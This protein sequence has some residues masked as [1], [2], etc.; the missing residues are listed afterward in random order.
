ML[1]ID[2][3]S[4]AVSKV[5]KYSAKRSFFFWLAHCFKDT[6]VNR[7]KAAVHLP[8]NASAATM[9]P[10]RL[11][12]SKYSTE[13]A[14]VKVFSDILFTIDAGD[15]ATFVLLDLSATFDTVDDS[16]RLD[17]VELLNAGSCRIWSADGR[18][19][20]SLLHLPV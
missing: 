15:L 2:V 12:W 20:T 19:F 10:V 9:P 18:T 6:R 16:K 3:Q 1:T 7:G 17:L 11:Y 4:C 14:P 5:V 8:R 13:T